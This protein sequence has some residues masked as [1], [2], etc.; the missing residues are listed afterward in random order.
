MYSLPNLRYKYDDLEPFFDARTMELHHTKHHQAYL[1]KLNAALASHPTL[2]DKPIEELLARLETLPSEIQV[3]VRNHG[4][5]H[6]NHAFFWQLLSPKPS[7][8]LSPALSQLLATFGDLAEFKAQF[9]EVALTRFGSGWAWLAL[10]P[11]G[12]AELFSTANQDSPWLEGKRPLLGLDLWEHAYYLKYQNR[13]AE[14][15]EA[16]WQV[17]DWAA[18]A[19]NLAG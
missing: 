12:E 4:G 14:Y 16:F 2:Q 19:A 3:A 5:G 18:V 1:D 10:T 13:R 9:A 6:A 11:T 7:E 15:I 8:Q 17:L